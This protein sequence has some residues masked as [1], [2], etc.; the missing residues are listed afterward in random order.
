MRMINDI[1]MKEIIAESGFPLSFPEEV[2]KESEKFN[3]AITEKEIKKRK[4]FR[5]CAHVYN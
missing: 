4:D 2:I 3:D 1:A 5:E